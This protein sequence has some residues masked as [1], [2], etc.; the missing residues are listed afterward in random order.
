GYLFENVDALE[1]FQAERARAQTVSEEHAG[2]ITAPARNRAAELGVDIEEVARSTSELVTAKV[3]DAF[4]ARTGG[5]SAGVDL[6]DPLSAPAG[7]MRLVIIGAGLGATQALDILLHDESQQA[8]AVV[9]DDPTRFGELIEGI[10]VVGNTERAVELFAAGAFDAALISVGT[11]VPARTRLR[12]RCE[13]A[14]LPLANVIDPTA[15]IATGVRMGNG[16]L[17]C[18]NCHFGTGT[19]IGDN[20]FFSAYNSFDH[21]SE[22][23]SDI[24]TGPGCMTSGLV[25]IGDR[26]RF[27]TGV[28]V[29]PHVVIGAGSQIA[30]GAVILGSV[31]PD[32]AV[33][34]KIVTTTV[35]PIRRG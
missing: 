34:T 3:V 9:D 33:K 16:N 31:P 5:G 35:V 8:V 27:G 18:A 21:H 25:K 1:R 12:Q 7:V 32:H 4:S 23:G 20:N 15:R 24:A 13:E 28:F 19:V 11:S 26:C 14:G 10:P 2:R 30:S 6:P 17:I 22:L 29:E